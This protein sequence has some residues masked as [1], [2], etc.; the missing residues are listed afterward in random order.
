M[1]KLI[2][3]GI[4]VNEGVGIKSGKSYSIA[5][6]HTLMPLADSEPPSVSKGFAS[7]SFNSTAELIRKIQHLQFPIEADVTMRTVIKYSKPETE[8]I[9]IKPI[10]VVKNA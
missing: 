6:I 3:Q 9:D 8:I 7:V 10:S 1:N 5:R 2:I 4:E